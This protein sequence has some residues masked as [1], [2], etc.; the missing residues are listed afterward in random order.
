VSIDLARR[1]GQAL[2]IRSESKIRTL[3]EALLAY[4]RLTRQS[5]ATPIDGDISASQVTSGTFADAR[6]AESNVTQHE[7]ALEI[8]ELQISDLGN[9]P[10]ADQAETISGAWTFTALQTFAA[11]IDGLVAAFGRTDDAA[12]ATKYLEIR[13]NGFAGLH[14]GGDRANAGGEPGGAWIKLSVDGMA[15]T[16]A[17]LLLARVQNAGEDGQG[18]AMTNSSANA[19]LI[20]EASA[21]PLEFGTNGAVRLRISSAGN[22]VL[23]GGNSLYVSERAAEGGDVAGFGQLW[24]KNTTPCQLW[25][26]DDAGNDTQIV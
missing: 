1:I 3:N 15:H 8:T 12:T 24:V 26:T 4:V 20:A 19:G 25:F 16:G 6:I 13:S 17:G 10:E 7:G 18:G 14:V 9:Y 2:D 5:A 11:A 23:V 21:N 22:A